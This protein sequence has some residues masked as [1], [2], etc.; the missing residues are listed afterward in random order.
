LPAKTFQSSS[1]GGTIVATVIFFE[2]PG[3]VNNSRQIK[4]L[5][6]AGHELIVKD[7]LKEKWTLENLYK[8]FWSMPVKEW[9]NLSAPGIKSA[10]VVPEELNRLS[11]LSLMLQDPL[12]IRRPLMQVG[13]QRM[14]GFN[15]AKVD[16]WIGLQEKQLQI[17][18]ETCPRTHSESRR[19]T[20]RPM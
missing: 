12:L 14:A 18:L 17:N 9:F 11:A 19:D 13:E 7:L 4:L 6:A 10:E 1:L 5:E 16:A 15:P 2:K 8:Y 3:C 20:D